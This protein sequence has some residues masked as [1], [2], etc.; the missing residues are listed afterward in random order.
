VLKTYDLCEIPCE[1]ELARRL[2]IVVNAVNYLDEV[3]FSGS[4]FPPELYLCL[5][6]P[7]SD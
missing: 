2:S 1:K 3:I 5:A 4:V 7:L 6:Q